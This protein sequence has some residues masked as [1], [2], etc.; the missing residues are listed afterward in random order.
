MN[1]QR[2][3]NEKQSG[4]DR[5]RQAEPVPRNQEECRHRKSTDERR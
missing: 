3:K 4:E 2:V 5:C 1:I